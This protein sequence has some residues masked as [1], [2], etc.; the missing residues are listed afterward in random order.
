MDL[1]I[2]WSGEKSRAIAEVIREWIPCVIQ[3]VKPYFTPEDIMKG[4]RW[5]FEISSKLESSK[6]GLIILTPTNLNAPWLMFEA[7]AL[8]KSMDTSKVCPLLFGVTPA[9]VVGPLVQFQ[10][11]EF[12]KTDIFKLVSSLNNFLEDSKLEDKTLQSSFEAFWPK[13]LSEIEEILALP[14]PSQP[15]KKTRDDRDILEEIL[16]LTRK[17]AYSHTHNKTSNS[18]HDFFEQKKPVTFDPESQTI[19]FWNKDKE[20]YNFTIDRLSSGSEVLDWFFQIANKGWCTG[21]HL[22]AFLSCLEEI[23]DLYFKQN[24]QGV[25]CPWGINQEVDWNNLLTK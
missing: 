25:F 10:C 20:V 2:S 17:T 18:I 14:E 23:T 6:M 16:R 7:G 9:D 12:N 19:S 3:A 4:Q 22:K 15:Q 11:S 1:F 24:A 13:L 5:S 8:S 21:E